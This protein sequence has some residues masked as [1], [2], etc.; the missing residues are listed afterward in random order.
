MFCQWCGKKRK[1][2]EKRCSGCN[3][4]FQPM[5]SSSV[6]FDLFG[7]SEEDNTTNKNGSDEQG[8]VGESSKPNVPI[9]SKAL[10]KIF[11]L[12]IL[13]LAIVVM[14]LLAATG[15]LVKKGNEVD[16]NILKEDKEAFNLKESLSEYT[17]YSFELKETV[18]SDET[19]QTVP[20]DGNDSEPTIS[21]G[22]SISDTYR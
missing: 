16:D 6:P 19:A 22:Y 8:A 4:E 18:R 3:A 15:Q 20:F 1:T 2:G 13:I 12:T 10:K 5:T 11:I 9:H 7:K 21:L 14:L 17:S